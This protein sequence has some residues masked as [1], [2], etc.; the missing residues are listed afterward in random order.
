MTLSE[1][2]RDAERKYLID[3]YKEYEA[4]GYTVMAKVAGVSRNSLI[5]L[6]YK[7]N[8]IKSNH[9]DRGGRKYATRKKKVL[10]L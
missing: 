1:A 2:F 4:D 8:I 10:L 9:K 7:Y 5:D 3:M 6:L